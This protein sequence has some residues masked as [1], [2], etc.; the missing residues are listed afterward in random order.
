MREPSAARGAFIDQVLTSSFAGEVAKRFA[1][2]DGEVGALYTMGRDR[3]SGQACPVVL[4]VATFP[5]TPQQGGRHDFGID[6]LEQPVSSAGE[7]A[8]LLAQF[9][10]TQAELFRTSCRAG[11]TVAGG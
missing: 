1:F 5:P 7:A 8:Q 6:F 2:A 9:G 4:Y 11:P 3:A 10:R